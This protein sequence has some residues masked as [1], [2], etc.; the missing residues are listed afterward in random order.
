M[1]K[2]GELMAEFPLEPQL[3]KMLLA[4]VEYSCSNQILSLVAMLSVPYCF[5]RPKV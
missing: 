2:N 1:T 5:Y 4:S 3:S